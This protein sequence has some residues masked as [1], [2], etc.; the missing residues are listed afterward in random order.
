ML[1]LSHPFFGDVAPILGRSNR[2]VEEFVA[3]AGLV[4]WPAR[5]DAVQRNLMIAAYRRTA[6][7]INSVPLTIVLSLP[8]S[9]RSQSSWRATP[10]ARDAGSNRGISA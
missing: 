6:L 9:P 8:C 7:L 4:Y 1:I 5:R 10:D 3:Q 2:L